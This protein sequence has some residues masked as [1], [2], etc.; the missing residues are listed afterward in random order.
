MLVTHGYHL[1]VVNEDLFLLSRL[2]LCSEV[3]L[4]DRLSGGPR[5]LDM[6][7]DTAADVL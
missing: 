7:G 5:E 6:N 4:I 1:G 3:P 2:L